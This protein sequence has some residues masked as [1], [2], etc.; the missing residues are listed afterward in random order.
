MDCFLLC[1]ILQFDG[2]DAKS[3]TTFDA[4]LKP[5]KSVLK[6]NWNKFHSIALS[7]AFEF[8]DIISVGQI[9]SRPRWERMHQLMCSIRLCH[10]IVADFRVV[11]LLLPVFDSNTCQ[12]YTWNWNETNL[13]AEISPFRVNVLSS[14]FHFDM[15]HSKH[16]IYMKSSLCHPGPLPLYLSFSAQT[17]WNAAGIVM[18]MYA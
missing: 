5:L 12:S 9:W 7:V 17:N 8:V 6:C 3:S 11:V 4:Y 2:F 16:L 14:S 18:A 1:L 13:C 15:F 10:R